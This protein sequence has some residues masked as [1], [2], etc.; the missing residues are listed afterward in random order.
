MKSYHSS[1]LGVILGL[2][3]PI[4]NAV[5]DGSFTC[6]GNVSAPQ[7]IPPGTYSSLSVPSGTACIVIVPGTVTVTGS[8]TISGT[9]VAIGSTATL[10]VDKNFNVNTGGIVVLGCGPTSDIKCFFD[11]PTASSHD[12]INGNVTASGALFMVFHNDTI[13][14]NITQSGGGGGVSCANIGV[15]P[16]F[17]LVSPPY[18]TYED[19]TVG[20]NVSISGV[21]TCWAG[22]IRDT[23]GKNANLNTITT[24][25]CDG[26]EFV[27]N[28]IA[29]NMNCSGN[30]PAPHIGDSMGLPNVIG[31]N[32]NGQCVQPLPLNVPPVGCI[33]IP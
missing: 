8:A 6:T 28:T 16:S 27:T 20:G 13:G 9:L 23:V 29:G 7:A 22:F 14:G 10:I 4:A 33:P 5:A 15:L 24:G 30:S 25:L 12:V 32:A 21:T 19:S 18:S 31:K 3:L 1:I 26:N 2:I 17:G 11:D